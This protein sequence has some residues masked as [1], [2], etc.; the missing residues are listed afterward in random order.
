MFT[1]PVEVSA[2]LS[3]FGRLFTH[4]SW[5][6]AQALLC[7][8]I[9]APANHTVTAALHALGLAGSAGFP[10]LPSLTESRPLVGPPSRL[11]AAYTGLQVD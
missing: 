3:A 6:R 9:L 2:V 10:E 8:M 11:R 1:P 5:A 4:P 7:G